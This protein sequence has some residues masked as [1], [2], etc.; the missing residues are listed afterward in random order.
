MKRAS[1]E[2]TSESVKVACDKNECKGVLWR[3]DLSRLEEGLGHEGYKCDVCK[4]TVKYVP[5]KGRS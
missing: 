5:K 3:V 4:R 2:V 1:N